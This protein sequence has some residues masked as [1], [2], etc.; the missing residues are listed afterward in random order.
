MM[1]CDNCGN[2]F[3]LDQS[4]WF[5]LEHGEDFMYLCS[6]SCLVELAWKFKEAQPK[7][8]KSKLEGIPYDGLGITT[9]EWLG[10][11]RAEWVDKPEEE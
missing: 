11:S 6:P 2:S 9:A 5:C 3:S 10:Q 1:L 8:S 7:L 4:D